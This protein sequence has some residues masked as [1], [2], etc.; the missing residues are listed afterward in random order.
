MKY[1]LLLVVPIT[2]VL[3]VIIPAIA[4]AQIDN[5]GPMGRSRVQRKREQCYSYTAGRKY[6]KNIWRMKKKVFRGSLKI[7]NIAEPSSGSRPIGE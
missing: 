2:A 5:N 7:S 4:F 6:I 1:E 3:L